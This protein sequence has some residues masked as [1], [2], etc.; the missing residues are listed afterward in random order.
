MI[1]EF[2][3]G[4]DGSVHDQ[5]QVWRTAHE[6]G[7][8]LTLKTKTS[9]NLHGVRCFHFG[10]GPPFLFEDSFV[11]SLTKKLKVCGSKAEL[12][13]WATSHGVQVTPC[14]HCLRKKFLGKG[15]VD[16][17]AWQSRLPEE[18]PIGPAY[19]EG[20]VQRILINRYER[21]PRARK[22]CI[23]HY[24]ATCVLCGFDSAAVYG[25]VMAGII[26]VHHLKPLSSVRTEYK[27][28]P[29]KDLRPVCP[30][31]HAALHRHEPPYS[32]DEVRKLLHKTNMP[33]KRCT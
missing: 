33:K 5:F 9:A 12:S 30:N 24:G 2:L 28:N 11:G 7:T 29:I 17:E 22:D 3:D 6:N 14:R 15:L 21:D 8:F 31:C 25:Q 18:L 19:S 1:T 27:V 4:V 10:G 32:L 26:H 23:Q 13:A 16:E 20:S